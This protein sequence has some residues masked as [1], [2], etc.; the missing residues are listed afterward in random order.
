MTQAGPCV[1]GLKRKGKPFACVSV[2]EEYISSV[3]KEN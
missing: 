3:V 1:K 2:T